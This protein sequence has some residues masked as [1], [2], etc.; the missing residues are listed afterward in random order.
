MFGV[1]IVT[2]R[3]RC[4]LYQQTLEQNFFPNNQIHLRTSL[5]FRNTIDYNDI[6]ARFRNRTIESYQPF[7]AIVSSERSPRRMLS[8]HLMKLEH[9]LDASLRSDGQQ[10][11]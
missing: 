9:R 4:R 2:A 8:S 6:Q 7:D 5:E 1:S 11:L 3:C 10:S